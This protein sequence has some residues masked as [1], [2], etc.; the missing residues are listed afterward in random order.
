LGTK[1]LIAKLTKE[2]S[3]H[4]YNILPSIIKE[5]NEKIMTLK[6]NISELGEPVPNSNKDK[7]T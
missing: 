2:M 6:E 7:L 5:I 3:T 1:S 4:I